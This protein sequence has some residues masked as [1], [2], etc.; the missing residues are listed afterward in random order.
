M[1]YKT[2]SIFP[3]SS[4][5]FSFFLPIFLVYKQAFGLMN[6]PPPAIPTL[7]LTLRYRTPE[8]PFQFSLSITFLYSIISSPPSHPLSFTLHPTLTFTLLYLSLPT[9]PSSTYS[10]IS[11]PSPNSC[12][13][14]F[15][16]CS[17]FFNT[18]FIAYFR[19]IDFKHEALH[20]YSSAP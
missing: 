16:I 20:S 12:S 8:V 11:I 13:F 4:F 19:H 3:S 1:T 9:H 6:V 17:C 7:T 10:P 15:L 18:F 14:I 5:T 2:L